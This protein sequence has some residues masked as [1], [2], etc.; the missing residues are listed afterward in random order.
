MAGMGIVETKLGQ[1]PGVLECITPE[2]GYLSS[3]TRLS[4]LQ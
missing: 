4:H 2:H 1:Y 3:R